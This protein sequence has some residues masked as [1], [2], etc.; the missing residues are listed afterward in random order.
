[1]PPRLY[2]K[3]K[4]MPIDLAHNDI[5]CSWPAYFSERRS[6][7]LRALPKPIR[8]PLHIAFQKNTPAVILPGEELTTKK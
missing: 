4:K 6:E 5:S 3:I 8:A 2:H 1:M 7:P